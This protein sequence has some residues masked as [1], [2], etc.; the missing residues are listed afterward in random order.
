MA[1]RDEDAIVAPGVA[2]RVAGAA[3]VGNFMEW[4][5]FAVYG[6]FAV[7]IGKVFFPSDN[8]TASLLSSLAV[9]GVAF[10]MR[11]IGG[12][13]LGAFGDRRRPPG[14]ALAVRHA[15]GRV[16]DARR[17]AA[18]VRERRHP[19]TDPA[20]PA[21]LPAGVLRRRRVD[22]HLGVPRRVRAARRRGLWGS[23]VSATAALGT[24]AGAL[25]A[26]A[27]STWLTAAQMQAWG[28]R[29]PFLLA[30]PLGAIGLYVRLRLEDTPV[31][32]ELQPRTPC[33]ATAA[34]GRAH[35]LRPIGLVMASAGARRGAGPPAL[36]RGDAR[37]PLREEPRFRRDPAAA[38][39]RQRA[40][41]R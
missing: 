31:F 21:A 16:D 23:V 2:R 3:A 14:G 41:V 11:P 12:L 17:G 40:A 1:H 30:A 7:T 25:V 13:V 34:A 5:D 38:P 37:R 27:L 18:H 39:V 9:F 32:R 19:R 22:R 6:F 24:L 20:H 10:L 35:N 8:E 33:Q 36:A 4:F 26:L 29:I 28:W 15:H